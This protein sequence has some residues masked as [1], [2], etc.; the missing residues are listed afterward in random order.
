MAEHLAGSES[1]FV[2]KMNEKAKQL[3]MNDTEFKNCHGIDEDG[4]ITS[5]YDI[6]LMSKE[7]LNKYP[8][9]TKYTSTWMD[10]LRDGK[11]ELVNTNKLIRTYDGATGLKTGSTS[12]ALYNLSASATRDNL[13]LVAVVMRAPSPTDR[14]SNARNLLD[15]GFSN[16]EFVQTSEKGK[17]VQ[18]LKVEKGIEKEVEL[19]YKESS[20]TILKRGESA[21]IE[22]KIKIDEKKNAPIKKGQKLGKVEFFLNEKKVASSDLIANSNIDKIGTF[23]NFKFISHNWWYLFR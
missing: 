1:V 21:N 4:H 18:N 12:L 14:V 7:L 16:F 11:A 22:T 19:V 5:S 17:V 15:Y 6:A 10:S 23:S 20:G 2:E 13:S 9:V 3:G 8:E